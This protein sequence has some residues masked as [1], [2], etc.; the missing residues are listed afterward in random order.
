[1]HN[2]VLISGAYKDLLLGG[3]TQIFSLIKAQNVQVKFLLIFIPG[4]SLI[5]VVFFFFF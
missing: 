1:M 3:G 2:N 4:E 5:F